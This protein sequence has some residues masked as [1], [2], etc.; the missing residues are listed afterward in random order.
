MKID[1]FLPT[2]SNTDAIGNEAL[3]IRSMLKKWGYSSKIF[4]ERYTKQT[5]RLFNPIK[6][7]KKS[8]V[9]IF[10]H[11]IG[12]K[13]IKYVK[14]E[15]AK[16][17]LL[18]HNVTPDHHF[19][20]TNIEIANLASLGRQQLIEYKDY[21]DLALADSEYNRQELRDIGYS[22][23]D[24]LPL[25]IDYE[26]YSIAHSKQIM[27]RYKDDYVNLLFVG[28]IAP[29]KNQDKIIRVFNFYNK[30][31]NP[32]SRLFLVGSSSGFEKYNL[33]LHNLKKRLGLENVI[34]TDGVSQQELISYFKIADLFLCMSEHEGFCV[35]LIESMYFDVPIIA[36]NK[37]AV[38]GT[39]G[40]SSIIF[41]TNNYLEIAELINHVL[42]DKSLRNRIVANQSK[43]LKSFEL[44]A[45]SKKLKELI[46]SAI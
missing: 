25:L 28:K 20:G 34:I 30:F 27:N 21:F 29:H 36:Y 42:S 37:T 9:I 7:H 43:R 32:K 2:L 4:A 31:I 15:D 24:V 19:W 13:I 22:N 6:K 33:Q 26:K 10:H 5:K 12:S 18:Y 35:P 8:D 23:T 16:K 38:P 1:Q 17:I 41:E 3:I 44:K 45:T 14:S 46:R 39:L 40:D 11:S